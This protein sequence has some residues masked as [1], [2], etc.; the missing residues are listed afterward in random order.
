MTQSETDQLNELETYFNSVE[1]PEIVK[2]DRGTT[3]H[4]VPQHVKHYLDL[5]KLKGLGQY[6]T[7]PSLDRLIELRVHMENSKE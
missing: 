1:I 5:I 2:F 4:N 6:T 3:W 7:Q